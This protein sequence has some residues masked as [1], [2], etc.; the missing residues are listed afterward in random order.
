MTSVTILSTSTYIVNNY[1]KAN[2]DF[3]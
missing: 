1:I 3:I 2:G